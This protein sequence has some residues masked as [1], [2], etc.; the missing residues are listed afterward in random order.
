MVSL[1]GRQ[2]KKEHL[3]CEKRDTGEFLKAANGAKHKAFMGEDRETVVLLGP[4]EGCSIGVKIAFHMEME[5]ISKAIDGEIPKELA[6]DQK[7]V[8]AIEDLK[9][10]GIS[11]SR[12]K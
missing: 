2:F 6:D 5:T 3:W 11:I 8:K 12:D 4:K 9:A 10:S 1:I 7:F